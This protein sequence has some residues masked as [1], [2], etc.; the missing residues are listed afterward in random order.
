MLDRAEDG[1][2]LPLFAGLDLLAAGLQQV[3]RLARLLRQERQGFQLRFPER[4]NLDGLR[5]V[6]FDT[7]VHPL[8]VRMG[9]HLGQI[10]TVAGVQDVKE[11]LS[12]GKFILSELVGEV[13]DE[14]LVVLK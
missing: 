13:A 10:V 1:D 2:L 14:L 12:R 5:F 11:E 3:D 8:L 9:E 7:V 6:S 4:T